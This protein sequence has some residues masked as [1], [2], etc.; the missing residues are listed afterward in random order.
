MLLHELSSHEFSHIETFN[1]KLS[2]RS[3]SSISFHVFLY[4]SFR[5]GFTLKHR[6]MFKS[7]HP[8]VQRSLLVP[9]DNRI[10]TTDQAPLGA[11]LHS[12]HRYFKYWKILLRHLGAKNLS[13]DKMGEQWRYLSSSINVERCTRRSAEH[14]S[15]ES[16]CRATYRRMLIRREG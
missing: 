13:N 2:T 4:F 10:L 16:V 8:H 3:L 5:L 11:S 14:Q 1:L 9:S 15:P 12:A 6:P 7:P